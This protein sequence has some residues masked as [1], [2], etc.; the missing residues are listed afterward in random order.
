M[1]RTW[2]SALKVS[3]YAPST[4]NS[5]LAMIGD[6]AT[7]MD[8]AS[9]VPN[10]RMPQTSHRLSGRCNPKMKAAYY[11]DVGLE[12]MVPDQMWIEEECKYDVAAMYGDGTLHQIDEALDYELRYSGSQEGSPESG[13]LWLMAD[14][15]KVGNVSNVRLRDR[16]GTEMELVLEQHQKVIVMI[17]RVSTVGVEIEKE[18]IE[19]KG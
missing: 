9:L 10:G 18:M 16:C 17:S 7:F 15:E 4:E 5:L 2:A 12:Q 3:T 13:K 19:D 8:C 1:E 14:K 11:P 6:T